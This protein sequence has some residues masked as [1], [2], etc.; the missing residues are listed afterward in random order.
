MKIKIKRKSIRSAEQQVIT[1]NLLV[2]NIKD[3]LNYLE[4]ELCE[5][6]ILE[7]LVVM[8]IP[9]AETQILSALNDFL[10]SLGEKKLAE[11]K[12]MYELFF[13]E[14]PTPNNN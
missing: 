1:N 4:P 12:E 8:L 5:T 13:N 10:N 14:N 3:T 9:M 11:V 7:K 6:A 2:S